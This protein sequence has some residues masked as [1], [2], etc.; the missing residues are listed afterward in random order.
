MQTAVDSEE[1]MKLLGAKLGRLLV[2]GES[3]DLTGDVGAGKTTFTK[4]LAVGLGIDEDVQSPTFTI[5]RTYDGR[6][7]IRLAHY[8]FYRLQSAGIM[9]DEL[10]ETLADSMAVTVIEWSD[11]VKGVLPTDHLSIHI[12]S[13]EENVRH[14]TLTAH[15]PK[16]QTLIEKLA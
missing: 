15:G 4:G 16:S 7:G 1:M 6:D 13:P 8:D 14:L 5:S 9:H 11:I 12:T 2:G 3:I 10:A